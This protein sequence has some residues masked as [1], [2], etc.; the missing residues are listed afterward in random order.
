MAGTTYFV[1]LPAA[2]ASLLPQNGR[3]R[4]DATPLLDEWASSLDP[5]RSLR[6]TVQANTIE[7]PDW[8]V[9]ADV[10]VS[11]T[12][13][14]SAREAAADEE[15]IAALRGSPELSRFVSGDHLTGRAWPTILGLAVLA[16]LRLQV[17]P[18]AHELRAARERASADAGE[19]R[20][21]SEASEPRPTLAP[22]P[23]PG[24]PLDESCSSD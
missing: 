9:S 22:L 19:R 18:A 12:A 15:V 1:M 21:A 17:G 23:P 8:K 16:A 14:R 6:E 2:A 11:A 20:S 7:L 3:R 4:P 5:V 10:A 13:V 24:S